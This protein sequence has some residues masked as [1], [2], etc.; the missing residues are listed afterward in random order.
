MNQTELSIL[1]AF[2][3]II[4]VYIIYVVASFIF[5]NSFKK[6][7]ITLTQSI[8]VLLYQKNGLTHELINL[9]YKRE[10]NE[11][12]IDLIEDYLNKKIEKEEEYELIKDSKDFFIKFQ[13]LENIYKELEYLIINK[14]INN[15]DEL[16]RIVNNIDDI[17]TR[18]TISTQ[19]YNSN[20]VAFNYYHNLFATKFI[21]KIFKIKEKE[22]IE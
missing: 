9:T 16:R 4:G 5:M 11:V 22:R 1:I 10:E 13:Y 2:I 6:K 15:E 8:S 3:I 18:F 14:R 12:K 17:N 21:K 19:L 7:I 20:V